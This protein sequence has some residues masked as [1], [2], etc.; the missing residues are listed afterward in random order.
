MISY[1]VPDPPKAKFT[2]VDTLQRTATGTTLGVVERVEKRTGN[3]M[4]DSRFLAATASPFYS[5][6][7][8]MDTFT[9]LPA[10]WN[11]YGSAAPSNVAINQARYLLEWLQTTNIAPESVHAS[12][13][14]GIA[15]S[16]VSDTI[17]RAEIESL[18]TGESYVLLYDLNGNSD[19]QEWPN[20]AHEQFAVLVT[21]AAH[22]RSAGLATNR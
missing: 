4:A 11:S 9:N 14:G 3:L 16:F 8:C 6:F 20:D 17:S 13:D 12:A 7:E 18:N 22:L 5:L 21:L 15:F 10:N 19:T 2:W 1:H